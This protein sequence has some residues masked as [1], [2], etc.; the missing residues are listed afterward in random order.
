MKR[1]I[2]ANSE[3]PVLDNIDVEWSDLDDGIQFTIYDGSG[4]VL[5]EELFSYEDVD[6]DSVYDS[7]FE[8]ARVALSQKYTLSDDVL[9]K[10]ET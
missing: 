2:K 1:Y 10:L 7:A 4:E 6:P 9:A 8:M 5:L 3:K